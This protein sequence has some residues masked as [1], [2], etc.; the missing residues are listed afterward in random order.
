MRKK[1]VQY[2]R[3]VKLALKRK[4]LVKLFEKN[5]WWL[6]REGGNHAI[7]TDGKASEPISRQADIKES[8]ARAIIKRRDL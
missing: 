1:C 6:K 7:Y 2:M 4:D 3:E 8:V 5:G